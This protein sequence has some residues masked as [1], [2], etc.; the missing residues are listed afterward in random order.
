MNVHRIPV[1][2]VERAWNSSEGTCVRVGKVGETR[3]VTWTAMNAYVTPAG[4]TAPVR[5]RLGHSDVTVTKAG[6]APTVMT[7]STNVYPVIDVIIALLVSTSR[8][9]SSVFVRMVYLATCARTLTNA[10]LL[11]RVLKI[12]HV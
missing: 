12:P 10:L 8:E 3:I 4:I 2:M 6:R 11:I 5:T 1:R 9:H 7:T